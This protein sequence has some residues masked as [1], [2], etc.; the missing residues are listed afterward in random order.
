[1]KRTSD[2]V[3]AST[4]P[5]GRPETYNETSEAEKKSNARAV[6]RQYY[7]KHFPFDVLARWLSTTQ[8]LSHREIAYAFESGGLERYN[9]YVTSTLW[10]DDVRRRVPL[11]IDIGGIF[12]CPVQ[13]HRQR[14]GTSFQ[15]WRRELTFDVDAN[16]YDNARWCCRGHRRVCT[17]CWP[18]IAAAA[19]VIDD[20]LRE[21]YGYRDICWFYSGRRGIHCWVR[22]KQ[23][24]RLSST[25]RRT[26]V[27]NF[28]I[29]ENR[30]KRAP[31]VRTIVTADMLTDEATAADAVPQT[32]GEMVPLTRMNLGKLARLQPCLVRA[33]RLVEGEFAQLMERQCVFATPERWTEVLALLPCADTRRS[34]DTAWTQTP[35]PA[36]LHERWLQL[37]EFVRARLHTPAY[38]ECPHII[39]EIVL[40]YMYPRIDKGVLLSVNH[41]LKSPFAAHPDTGCISVPLNLSRIDEFSPEQVLTIETLASG[42]AE[43]EALFASMVRFFEETINSHG[44]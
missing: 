2:F 41:M 1:M 3:L 28:T 4:L 14:L 37:C 20:Q 12:P 26:A 40:S 18:L 24:R 23:V 7:Q 10:A 34:L 11:K 22:D 32:M 38:A 13:P 43:A 27:E 31:V 5:R 42:S 21:D 44:G 39:E 8:S 29:D 33:L 15:P 19:R 16:D 6:L 30:Y 17:K 36:N 9:G 35:P 25:L